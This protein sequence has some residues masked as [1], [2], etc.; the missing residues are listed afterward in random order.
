M[1]D[2]RDILEDVQ[3]LIAELESHPD[4]AVGARLTE[5]LQGIDTIHRT[6]LTHLIGAIQSMALAASAQKPIGSSCQRA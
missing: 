1:S 6:A 3:Q 5:L 2:S 4:A